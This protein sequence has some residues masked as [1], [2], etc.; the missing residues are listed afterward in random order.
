MDEPD[1]ANAEPVVEP[2][3]KTD[4]E[5]DDDDADEH[6]PLD[7]TYLK[8]NTPTKRS[9]RSAVW[10]DIKR[11]TGGHP[12]LAKGYTHVCVCR[13]K[14]GGVCNSFIK[15]SR[16]SGGDKAAWCT[17][18]ANDHL[19]KEVFDHV[20]TP[21]VLAAQ[22]RAAAAHDKKVQQQFETGVA[23]AAAGS[24]ASATAK[25]KGFVMTPAMKALS[26]QARWYVSISTY[27][28]VGRLTRSSPS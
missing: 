12:M 26:S 8:D 6:A 15:L 21:A 14:D 5:L 22:G 28:R 10:S 23:S 9:S 7:A 16:K 19:R 4:D 13:R 11:L 27:V 17:T 1:A 24:A 18:K 3:G 25:V 2:P 20:D